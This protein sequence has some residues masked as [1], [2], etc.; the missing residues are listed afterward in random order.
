MKRKTRVVAASA[1]AGALVLAGAGVW[2]SIAYATGQ[3][4]QQLASVNSSL[5]ASYRT[6]QAVVKLLTADRASASKLVGSV[7]PLVD[8]VTGLVDEQSRKNLS[9]AVEQLAGTAARKDIAVLTAGP[10]KPK[11]ESLG[12]VEAA[13]KAARTE[14]ARNQDLALRN[15][16][17]DTLLSGQ[18]DAVT[19]AL[20]S[21][22]MS[23]G[24]ASAAVLAAGP[25]ADA[26]V[27]DAFAAQAT[28]VNSASGAK[29]PDASA[30]IAALTDY[31]AK[32]K[33]VGESQAAAVAQAAAEAAQQAAAEQA[34]RDAAA[35]RS[36]SGSSGSGSSQSGSSGES[37]Q[38]GAPSSRPPLGGNVGGG[39][40]GG[41]GG[42]VGCQTSNGM[43]GT[44]RC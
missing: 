1:A 22:G 33:S 19:A 6:D 16:T 14:L 37:S 9:G 29:T 7:R 11:D 3:A 43:G 25:L 35:S 30:L 42:A 18:S 24:T 40:V 21:V 27:R 13:V 34:A 4:Q 17:S 28:T 5:A 39:S 26:A 2:G 32:G 31:V 38:G 23:A 41:S 8:A 12:A 20:S 44:T 10:A 15:R 36:S